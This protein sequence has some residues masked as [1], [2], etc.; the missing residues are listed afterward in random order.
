MKCGDVFIS[1]R[2]F[3][4]HRHTHTAHTECLRS[5]TADQFISTLSILCSES[6]TLREMCPWGSSLCQMKCFR[7]VSGPMDTAVCL[8][9]ESTD[10][11]ASWAELNEW[12][13]VCYDLMPDAN[14]Q[15]MGSVLLD[16]LIFQKNPDLGFIEPSQFYSCH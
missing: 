6:L 8:V 10:P 3:V 1:S 9:S 2:Q 4:S 11:N 7:K 16:I 13:R 15:D 14:L 12:G 5:E